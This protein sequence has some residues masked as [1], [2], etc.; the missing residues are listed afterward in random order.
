MDVCVC[1][2]VCV[3]HRHGYVRVHMCAHPM[4]SSMLACTGNCTTQDRIS[5][6]LQKVKETV[7]G[8]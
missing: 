2:C 3:E 6:L 7:M 8:V 5:N 4:H 1:V